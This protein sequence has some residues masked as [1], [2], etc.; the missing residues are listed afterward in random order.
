MIDS[1]DGQLDLLDLIPAEVPPPIDFT[2]LTGFTVTVTDPDELDRIAEAWWKAHHGLPHD[3]WRSFPGWHESPTGRSAGKDNPHPTFMYCADLRCKHWLTATSVQ[4]GLGPCSCV[5]NGG[6]IYRAYCSACDWWTPIS[7]DENA[8]V[9]AHLDHCW[10]GWETLPVIGAPP[11]PDAKKFKIPGDY[12]AEWQVP[13]APIKTWRTGYGTRHV[14]MR[15]PFGGYD[16][17]V[18]KES[19]EVA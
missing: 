17:G 9:E 8:A 6:L 4:R 2:G 16:V 7:N 15:S 18:L 12:P 11:G 13:G 1:I 3:Q 5:G 19:E 14:P 10:A